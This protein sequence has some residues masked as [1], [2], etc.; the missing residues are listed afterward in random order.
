MKLF[1]IDEENLC[2]VSE[3]LEDF[4]ETFYERCDF[5]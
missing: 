3:T 1:N 4:S 5:W 2:F